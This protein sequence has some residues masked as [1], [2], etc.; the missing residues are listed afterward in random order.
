M[1][2]TPPDLELRLVLHGGLAGTAAPEGRKIVV[3]SGTTLA[4]ALEGIGV[5]R[6]LIG[7]ASSG[8]RLLAPETPLEADCVVEVY[9]VFGGG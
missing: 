7:V 8:G 4:E 5:D 2:M 6:G 3:P 1:T 9:P